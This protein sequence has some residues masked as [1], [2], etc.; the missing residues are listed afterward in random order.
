MTHLV[1]EKAPEDR[2]PILGAASSWYGQPW[3]NWIKIHFNKD[4]KEQG[5]YLE[6]SASS[7][8]IDEHL[9][10]PF[11]HVIARTFETG[12]SPEDSDYIIQKVATMLMA[13]KSGAEGGRLVGISE[14]ENHTLPRYETEKA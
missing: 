2:Y 4:V 9:L 1:Y 3:R 14:I 11:L 6:G 8:D 12:I 7:I 10:M 5:V 13:H